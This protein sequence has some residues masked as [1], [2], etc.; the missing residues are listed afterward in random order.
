MQDQYTTQIID[1]IELSVVGG[2]TESL[3][4]ANHHIQ[5]VSHINT[6]SLIIYFLSPGANT[7]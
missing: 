2:N 6:F 5:M 7:K 3:T 4:K 1:A